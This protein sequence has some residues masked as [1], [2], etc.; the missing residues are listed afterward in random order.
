MAPDRNNPKRPVWH[1]DNS[2]QATAP[3]PHVAGVRRGR[4]SQQTLDNFILPNTASCRSDSQPEDAQ[5]LQTGYSQ[6]QQ[7]ANP[8]LAGMSPRN[9]AQASGNQSSTRKRKANTP[10]STPKPVKARK[11]GGAEPPMKRAASP[12]PPD[13]DND[14]VTTDSNPRSTDKP[15]RSLR[16]II[17]RLIDDS[18]PEGLSFYV[19]NG[20]EFYIR[21]G[22]LCSGTDAPIHVMNLFGMLKNSQGKQVLNTIN[23]FGCEI[24]PFKQSFL[25]RNSK[26]G[27]LFR[28]AHDFALGDAQKAH[29]VTGAEADIPSV[30]MF[31][32]GTS[33][34]DFS[35]LSSTKIKDYAGL[36]RAL[37]DWEALVEKHG[38]D[39]SRQHLSDDD[40]RLAIDAM[41]ERTEAKNTSTKTFAAAMNYVK[42]RQPKIVV[43][44][45]VASA[46]WEQLTKSVFPL[47]GYAAVVRS[48]DTKEYHLPQTRLRK[49]L[50]AF[51]HAHFTLRGA[52]KLCELLGK[53]LK[54]LEHTHANSVNDFLLAPNSLELHRARNEMEL[55]A[56]GGRDQETKWGFS[57]SRHTAFRREKG[58]PNLRLWIR[59]SESANSDAPSK[60][61]RPWENRQPSRVS[62][63]LDCIFVICLFGRDL[64]HGQYDIRFKARII[65]CSQNVDRLTPTSV[66]GRT[67][68]LTPNAIPVLTLDARPITGTESLRLQGLPVENF[69]MSVETQ[70]QLQDLAGNAMTTTVVGAVIL[71]ALSAVART[72]DEDGLPWLAEM[73]QQGNFTPTGKT[74]NS[75]HDGGAYVEQ[76]LM[77]FLN[78]K[79]WAYIDP[80]AGLF[81]PDGG[82]RI[83]L[84]LAARCRQHCPCH[85]I[86]SYSSTELYVCV[87]CDAGFCKSCKGN[88]DHALIKSPETLEDRMYLPHAQ[89]KHELR[90]LF[91]AILWMLSETD[92]LVEKLDQA[93]LASTYTAAQ[94]SELAKAIIAGLCQTTY[95]RQFIDITDA[96]RLEYTADSTFILRVVI[97]KSEIIW[98]LHL[99]EWSHAGEKLSDVLTTKQPIARAVLKP[100]DRSQ[101]PRP[102]AWEF[103][104]PHKVAFPLKF[105][106]QDEQGLRIT[107][108]GDL[109]SMPDSLQRSIK[110]LQGSFW[111]FHPECGFP[112]NAL[113]VC[114]RP[115]QKLF[116]FKDVD[117]IGP[118]QKDN[119]VISD[120]NREMGR[121]PVP[122]TRPVL[123]RINLVDQI[124]HKFR[125]VLACSGEFLLSKG[126]KFSI[127]A[128]VDGWWESF[129]A[130]KIRIEAFPNTDYRAVKALAT[131]APTSIRNPGSLSVATKYSSCEEYQALMVTYLPMLGDQREA[132]KILRTIENLDLAQQLDLAEFSRLIG[133]YYSAVEMGLI[134]T[135]RR[136]SVI[137]ENVMLFS[138]CEP[139]APQLPEVFY[140]K[141]ETGRGMGSRASGTAF[142]RHR[143]ADQRNYDQNSQSKPAPFR[144][145]HAVTSDVASDFNGWVRG[146]PGFRYVKIRILAHGH[147]LLQ[148]AR[149]YLSRH[150][151]QYGD[152][153]ETKGTFAMEVGVIEDPRIVLRPIKILA[154]EPVGDED[155]RQPSG[156]QNGLSLFKEQSH[157]LQW[158]LQREAIERE[159]SF[160]EKEVAEI[161]L[162]QFRLRIHADAQRIVVRRGR[163]VADNVGFGK[164][165]VCLGLIDVQNKTD[166]G[167]FL[168]MRR[169][170]KHLDGLIH[171]HATLVIV[172]NQLTR[173]WEDEAKR[174]LDPN[175]YNIVVIETFAVLQRLGISGLKKA[176]IIIC[177]NK[178]F[179]EN[180]YHSE[181][182]KYCR[183]NGL[184]KIRSLQKVYRAWYKQFQ[185]TFREVRHEVVQIL[186]EQNQTSAHQQRSSLR[187]ELDRM[188]EDLRNLD[189]VEELCFAPSAAETKTVGTKAASKAKQ[190]T[191]VDWIPQLIFEVFSFSRIIWDEFPYE[192]AP[193]TEFVAN[194][195]TTSRWVLSGTP[196]LETLGDACK[197]A[198]LFSVHLARP[199]R[200]VKGRQPSVC[201]NEP[202]GPHSDLETTN[203]FQSRHSPKV[204]AERHE[205]ALAFVQTFMRKND[206][207]AEVSKIEKPLVL[208]MS[209]LSFLAHAEL[210]LELRSRQYN[211]NNVGADPRRRLMSRISWKGKENGRDRSVEALMIRASASSEDILRQS[212]LAGRT[213]L[214]ASKELLAT[215]EEDI[216]GIE[217]RCRELL[218]KAFFLAYRLTLITISNTTAD[219]KDGQEERQLNYYQNLVD[220][221]ESV[222]Q[223]D[224][225]VFQSWDAFES[226]KR[227]L[228]W[229]SKERSRWEMSKDCPLDQVQAFMGTAF[230]RTKFCDAPEAQPKRPSN[231]FLKNEKLRKSLELKTEYLEKFRTFLTKTP[232]HSRRW[233]LLDTVEDLDEAEE[234][235]L[236]LEW[237]QKVPWEEDYE[238]SSEPKSRVV[239]PISRL[240]APSPTRQPMEFDF[241]HLRSLDSSRRTQNDNMRNVSRE[242]VAA[243]KKEIDG[244]KDA[245]KDTKVFWEEEC[246][247]RGLVAK[248]T[249]KK[250]ELIARVAA[251]RNRIA[252]DKDYVSPESCG[253]AMDKFP[254]EGKKKIRGGN[255]EIIFNTLMQTV[256]SLTDG[257][258]RAVIAHAKRNLQKVVADILDGTW[259]C[260]RCGKEYDE[261]HISLLCGHVFCEQPDVDQPCGIDYC[262]RHLTNVCIP[263]SKI[264]PT[265]RVVTAGS[266]SGAIPQDPEPYLNSTAAYPGS[267]KGPKVRAVINLIRR[268]QKP[269]QVVV[270]VQNEAMEKDI[271]DELAAAGITHVTANMLT[272]N[273]A[274]HLE[275][276][277]RGEFKVL[278]QTINSEQ[279]AGSNLHNANHVI[280]VSPLVSRKQC[281]WDDHMKQALGRCVRFRQSKTVHVYHMLMDETIEVDT[282]E[283][284]KKKEIMVTKGQAIARFNECA[285]TDF[286]ARYEGDSAA[287]E[288][289]MGPDEGRAV[290]ILPRDDVQQLMGDDY[291]SLASIKARK[292]IDQA[293]ADKGGK[294]NKGLDT[295]GVEFLL[296][297]AFDYDPTEI[298]SDSDSDLMG[299]DGPVAET[300]S[301]DV[302]MDND[303]TVVDQD[304]AESPELDDIYSAD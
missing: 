62:D 252:T 135:G 42:A 241:K 248:S 203:L 243:I 288:V 251:D 24:E 270:F 229:D 263:L 190:Q 234:E 287:A 77:K 250:E 26:P 16:E 108:I 119:F 87:V 133:P 139:C 125:E 91:P 4:L 226:A 14:G 303:E 69:D 183:T 96:I 10:K 81:F 244:S 118:A 197:V 45:N 239:V 53:I 172:P 29:L 182:S 215:T 297:P 279:S 283:W 75:W 49:Y 126:D 198:Y 72:A 253:L 170:N 47:M 246:N 103:W 85:H 57:K 185:T 204:L 90:K 134:G 221:V 68:C 97:E 271:Y 102:R 111:E 175:Q 230:Q 46:P 168:E 113:W 165:A 50:I 223:A 164:T 227:I 262:Q 124:H 33:C 39:L 122:E 212:S 222:L 268:V 280:F 162:E 207:C 258:E 64:D 66:F 169:K 58:I 216:R 109:G 281:E 132:T 25:M 112:E 189:G 191:D 181:L 247:R 123:L 59:W 272:R 146:K 143:E 264:T 304:R 218:A 186:E 22:T 167:E 116:L 84:N 245:L 208:S 231:R 110:D 121:T 276:F 44:E 174:F 200:I 269:Q 93:L 187:Q 86:L 151:V 259:E 265:E 95:Q 99:D 5:A 55:A 237:S 3:N 199:L 147:A 88:P 67:G 19:D 214:E 160:V 129:D 209:T 267:T 261:H 238:N 273:E 15:L 43:F 163:V 293:V 56:Q 6:N 78:I 176:D 131:G 51:S 60:M 213:D 257:L 178:V 27:L 104:V 284:R 52:Q 217:D 35:S 101:F 8:T 159:P 292:T 179:Q 41:L 233:F 240:R 65:D 140:G 166:R 256:D 137:E 2:S 294:Q 301:A 18:Q 266:L 192:N 278:V 228:I 141:A 63:L 71:A 188:R 180:K 289:E 12:G 70:A 128:F 28:D 76:G 34:V 201:E 224:M 83:I 36:P 219:G 80:G 161:Y 236:S 235:L 274:G 61:W 89:A 92:T 9:A 242:Q 225:S 158:M 120:I 79:M 206:R 249:D 21:V 115:N 220:I 145:D 23:S 130:H 94:R 260:T 298:A 37:K 20:R 17:Q 148:Q 296:Q 74:G 48:L 11:R 275:Q 105:E 193:V 255:M 152:T 302:A 154:P 171:L 114:N 195:G 299:S 202:L 184:D 291:L 177:S 150:P 7:G 286:L 117:P 155:A 300:G 38:D 285:P 196:P 100:Q 194:C 127:G 211:A 295:K 32:A 156:F 98:Y 254:Q 142:A 31:V 149:A 54:N 138:D 30:D 40:W 157:S 173:Q 153:K 205:Q 82:V 144:I 1:A 232:L 107:E 277:K 106:V 282:L 13:G 136:V 290:S 210:Q 73:F